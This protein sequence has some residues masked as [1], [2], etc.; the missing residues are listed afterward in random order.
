MQERRNSQ[1]RER[2]GRSQLQSINVAL[3]VNK[4]RHTRNRMESSWTDINYRCRPS[5]L[6][7]ICAFR[8][9]RLRSATEMS[10]EK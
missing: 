6:N 5:S 7:G 3:P 2:L 9:A 1:C 8:V 4:N 10:G